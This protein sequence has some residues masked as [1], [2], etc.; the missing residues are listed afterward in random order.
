MWKVV[1]TWLSKFKMGLTGDWQISRSTIKQPPW[2]QER[3]LEGCHETV[4]HL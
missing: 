3:G 4:E 1:D 2:Y